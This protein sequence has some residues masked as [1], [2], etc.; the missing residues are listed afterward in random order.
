MKRLTT[1]LVLAIWL[2]PAQAALIW[3]PAPSGDDHGRGTGLLLADGQGAEARLILPDLSEREVALEEGSLTLSGTGMDNYHALVATRDD[4][5][6]HETAIRYVYL[7][8]KPSGHSPSE[9]TTADK[10]RLEI[11][12]DPLPREHQR[13][14]A[15]HQA[16]WRLLFDGRPLTEAAVTLSTS[17]GSR[18]E[19]ETDARGRLQVELPDDFPETHPGRRAN[20]PAEFVL[21][22]RHQED[23]GTFVTRYSAAYFVDD[24]HWKPTWAGFAVLGGGLFLG[25]GLGPWIRRRLARP[26]RPRKNIRGRKEQ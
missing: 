18:L 10:A 8:G 5:D 6:V 19:R 12:P 9:L 7:H 22:V 26:V 2:S 23:G 14:Q 16:A 3:E 24:G 17:H 15:N 11:R 20:R 1:L 21:Q 25:L 13:Y 4:G